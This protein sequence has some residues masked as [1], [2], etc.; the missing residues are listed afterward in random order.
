MM[1]NHRFA[2]KPIVLAFSLSGT[3]LMAGDPV[4]MSKPIPSWTEFDARQVL[5]DSPWSKTVVAGIT[6]RQSEDERRAGGQMG[7]AHGV[8]YDG[9]GSPRPKP[10]LPIKSV[11]DLVKPN[12]YVAPR[13]EYLRLRLCWESALPVRA[14]ELK[15]GVIAPPILMDDGYS[16]AVYGIPGE[17]FKGDPKSLGDPLKSLAA[18]KREGKKDVKPSSAEVFTTGDGTVVVYVFPLSA[19]ISRQDGPVALSAQ[20]GRLV[21]TQ[22]FNPE[23]MQF[24]G[25]PAF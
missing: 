24:Q 16:I 13:T 8:G 25:K 20:I 7:E 21:F 14:A 19:E 3:L 18:L 12:P 9:V 23:E 22:S 2:M 11:G 17:Y 4:W 10:Q 1:S 15:A 5:R 6:R